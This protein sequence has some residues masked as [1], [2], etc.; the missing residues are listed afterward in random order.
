LRRFIPARFSSVIGVDI[1]L[2]EI[3]FIHLRQTKQKHSIEAAEV[4]EFPAGVIV[5]G[6]IKAPDKVIQGIRA[7]VQ[8][9]EVQ[10]YATCVAL[11]AQSVMTNRIQLLKRLTAAERLQEIEEN[12]SRYFPDFSRELCYDYAVL[13][14][15]NDLH[16]TVVWVATRQEQLNDYVNVV[17]QAGLS[18]KAVDVDLYALARAA[19]Y[20]IGKQ[21]TQDLIALL[22][23]SIDSVL[24]VVLHNDEVTYHLQWD[25]AEI[26]EIYAKLN[27]AFQWY[28]STH[29]STHFNH[30]YLS[31]DREKITTILSQISNKIPIH[32]QP[33]PLFQDKHHAILFEKMMVCYGLALRRM[34]TW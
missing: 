9:T 32:A 1:R 20:A 25:Y 17:E 4:I 28:C 29:P 11:P 30:L 33:I 22:D 18:V 26:D 8:Q 23:V 2:N 14:D 19:K 12:I 24:F 5:D 7:L 3:R 27:G 6:K 21:A 34:P 16:N 15:S 10:H 13:S 31:G